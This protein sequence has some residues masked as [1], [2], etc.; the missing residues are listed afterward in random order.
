MG[1]DRDQEA[2]FSHPGSCSC[3]SCNMYATRLTARLNAG[4]ASSGLEPFLTPTTHRTFRP[5][6]S[7]LRDNS[8]SETEATSTGRSSS[9]PLRR[10][11][12]QDFLE[13][14]DQP[15]TGNLPEAPPPSPMLER[16]SQ[17]SPVPSLS[18]ENARSLEESDPIGMLS[19]MLPEVG[20][21]SQ[22]QR[23]YAFKVIGLSEQLLLT[24]WS[25]L[26]SNVK[27]QSSGVR[28]VLEN[29]D[30]HGRMLGYKLTLKIPARS[31]GAAILVI[32]T[33][34]LMNFAVVSTSVTCSG[35]W[36]VIRSLW[37]QRGERLPYWPSEF[38]LLPISRRNVGIQDSTM[39]LL[40]R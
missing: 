26:P 30:V 19:G 14:M 32:E 10:S 7:T 35:G 34:S 22:S 28:P 40:R 27:S 25:L 37:K 9:R 12:A 4:R 5:E 20:T 3:V 6:L 33:L 11:L 24:T 15:P 31:F 38:G 21:F 1:L 18:S 8:N 13:S 23:L 29:H 39:E 36:T 16:S 2:Y 17:G